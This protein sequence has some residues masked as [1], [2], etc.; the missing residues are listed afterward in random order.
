MKTGAS[1]NNKDTSQCNSG[2]FQTKKGLSNQA[3]N[4]FE[5]MRA[6]IEGMADDAQ[7]VV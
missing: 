4:C 3:P 1:Q 7:R 6:T 2:T 5:A